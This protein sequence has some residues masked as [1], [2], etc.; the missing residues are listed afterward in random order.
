MGYKISR[1]HKNADWSQTV[2]NQI[3]IAKAFP[4]NNRLDT[5]SQ[6]RASKVL[7]TFCSDIDSEL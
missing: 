3:L 7:I 4:T 5:L 1:N 6:T 2:T